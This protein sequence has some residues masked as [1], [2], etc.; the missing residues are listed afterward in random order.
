[1][2]LALALLAA[3]AL[4]CSRP[5]PDATPDGAVRE[6]I[7]RMNAQVDDPREAPAAYALLSKATHENLEKRAERASLIEGR[8]A[9]GFEMLATGR[10]ALRFAPKRFAS[11][12]DGNQATVEVTGEG[13][14]QHATVHCV[15]EGRV[16]RV[17]LALPELTELP[18][19]SDDSP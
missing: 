1:V 17:D 10:F 13:P 9:S 15:K 4:S 6:W 7:D 16:W 14:D 18:R 19:R 11:R 2:R 5:P 12:V 3:L 8:H